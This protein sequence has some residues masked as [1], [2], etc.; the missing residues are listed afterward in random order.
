MPQMVTNSPWLT[1]NKELAI[2]GQT[3]TGKEYLNPLMADS[4]PKTNGVNTPRSDEERLENQD[5]MDHVQQQSNDP[6]LSRR[7]TLGSRE[8]RLKLNELMILCTNTK[9]SQQNNLGKDASKQGRIDIGDIDTDAEITLID[10][11]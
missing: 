7:Y 5:L 8:D 9:T 2:P 4:L 11:T 10:E 6:P 3:T 1:D